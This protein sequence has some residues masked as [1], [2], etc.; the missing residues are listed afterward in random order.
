MYVYMN[1]NDITHYHYGEAER[2]SRR[3]ESAIV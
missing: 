1:I 3:N 2:P